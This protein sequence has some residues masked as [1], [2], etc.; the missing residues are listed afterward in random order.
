MKKTSINP[1]FLPMSEAAFNRATEVDFGTYRWLSISGTA[2]VGPERQTLYPDDFRSQVKQTYRNIVGILEERAYSVK[3][4]I[5][6]RVYL[7]DIYSHYDQFNVCRDSFFNE[8]NI[9]REEVG[10]SVCVEAKLCR[11]D[12]LVEIE[13]EAVKQM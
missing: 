9:S 2:S 6:W 10:S 8:H 12:L 3:D 7:K 4:V 5:K 13:A 1:D 11:E